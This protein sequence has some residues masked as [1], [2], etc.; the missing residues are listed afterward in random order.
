MKIIQESEAVELFVE[1][2][3]AMLPEFELT[4]FN[5]SFVAQICQRL[6]G[7]ALAIEL[8]ASRIKM[9]KVEQIAVR[10]DD[11]FSLLTNGNRTALPRQQTLRALIDWSYNL[12]SEE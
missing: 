8:A 4:E 6:D 3:T 5:A 2:A 7:I 1:R 11:A 12:L 10:L 9:F